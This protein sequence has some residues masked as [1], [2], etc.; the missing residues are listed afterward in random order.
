MTVPRTEEEVIRKAARMINDR[1][2]EYRKKHASADP[3]VL[4]SATTIQFVEELIVA[5]QLNDVNPILEKI[6]RINQELG[7][8]LKE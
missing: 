6:Q 1:I 7:E 8:I 5:R 4:L 3:L 2:T